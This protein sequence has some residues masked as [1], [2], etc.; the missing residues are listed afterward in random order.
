MPV[1]GTIARALALLCPLLTACGGDEDAGGGSGVPPTTEP[2]SDSSTSTTDDTPTTSTSATDTETPTSEPET[3]ESATTTTTTT[4]PPAPLTV[5]CGAPPGGAKAAQYSHQ[6]TA[7]G[8]TPDY[9]WSASGLP[10]GLTIDPDSGE[11]SGAPL[12]P[13]DYVIELSVTDGGGMAAMASCPAIAIN[14]QF[15]VDLDLLPGGCISGDQTLLDFV[16]GGDGTAIE[17]ATPKGVGDGVLP[18]GITVDKE[19]CKSTGAIAETR[20]GTYAW[21]VRARQSGVDVYAPFC[22]TQSQQAPKAYNIVG[23]HSGKLDNELEPLV[24]EP[25]KGAPLLLDGDADPSFVVDKGACGASCFF[26]FLFQVSPS[27][28]GTGACNQ[29]KDKCFG[30]CPLVADA[31]EPDGDKQ[32]GCSLIPKVGLKTGFAHEMWAKGEP[33]PAEFQTRPFVL[34]WSIDY[35]VTNVMGQ[36]TGKDAILANGDGSNLAFAVIVRPQ[37]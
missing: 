8:G 5:D 28:F 4:D 33:V 29:D 24:L 34:Q 18:A 23:N 21:I 3:S 9:V 7:A 30:L 26:G 31:N 20:Y 25:S 35:C 11:I 2:P 12:T 10:D 15:G 22:A 6:P 17:C 16:V 1:R 32:I 37:P 36:C 27:P 13:G 14:E 19:K